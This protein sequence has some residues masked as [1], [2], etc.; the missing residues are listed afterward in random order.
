MELK[1]INSKDLTVTNDNIYLF[2]GAAKQAGL[3]PGDAFQVDGDC[4][5]FVVLPGYVNWMPERNRSFSG[6]R[7]AEQKGAN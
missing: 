7:V 6:Y 2:Y 3:K 1:K 5:S 4:G